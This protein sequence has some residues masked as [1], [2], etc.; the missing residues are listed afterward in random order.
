FFAPPAQAPVPPTPTPLTAV[1]GTPMKAGA[2]T[3]QVK[4]LDPT[5]SKKIIREVPEDVLRKMLE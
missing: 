1:G 4:S 5:N 2:A 3:H